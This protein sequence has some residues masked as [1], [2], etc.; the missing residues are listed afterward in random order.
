MSAL[1]V[2]TYVPADPQALAALDALLTRAGASSALAGPRDRVALPEEVHALLVQAIEAMR[3]GHA[4]TV[5]PHAQ[6]LTT[7]QA[8][9]LLGVS[10][11]TLVKIIDAGEIPCERTS[12]RR[13]LLLADVVA[14]RRRRRDRQLEAIA[15]TSADLDEVSIEPTDLEQLLKSARRAN[16]ERKRKPLA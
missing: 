6:R 8:A 13:T 7:Q 1:E 16:A 14:Y 12:T 5:T 2:H 4:V 11:P 10:R 9:D 3:A 15:A